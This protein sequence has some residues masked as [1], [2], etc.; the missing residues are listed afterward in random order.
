MHA[1]AAGMGARFFVESLSQIFIQVQRAETG[2]PLP[3]VPLSQIF[4]QVLR[5][6]T[7]V[8]FTFVPLSQIFMQVQ[9]TET[10]VLFPI[11]PL[12]QILNLPGLLNGQKQSLQNVIFMILA[13]IAFANGPY[14]CAGIQK[15]CAE[16][17]VTERK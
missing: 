16:I 17:W 14:L 15:T 9:M 13:N 1:Q 11:V 4:I 6:E 12:R 10:G 3:F 8:L 7:G 5:A 2:V